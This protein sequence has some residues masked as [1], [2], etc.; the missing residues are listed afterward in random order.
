MDRNS[1]SARAG[2]TLVL[3]AAMTSGAYLV[4]FVSSAL[5]VR[6]AGDA[7]ETRDE[8]GEEGVASAVTH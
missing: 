5:G 6:R 4:D 3:I 7:Q 1:P 8:H 2:L